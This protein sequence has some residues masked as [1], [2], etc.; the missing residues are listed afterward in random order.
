ML[1]PNAVN[2]FQNLLN[3]CEMLDLSSAH[4]CRVESVETT[5]QVLML[6]TRQASADYRSKILQNV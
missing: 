2:N 3:L 1:I 6:S 4:A 5:V